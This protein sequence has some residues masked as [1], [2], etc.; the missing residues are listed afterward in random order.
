MFQSSPSPIARS[1]ALRSIGAGAVA[2]AVMASEL[3]VFRTAAEAQGF[4]PVTIGLVNSSSDAPFFLA[5]QLGYYRDAGIAAK[6]IAFNGGAPAM[7]SSVGA[8]QID[9]GSGGPSAGLYN[10]IAGKIDLRMVA[11][12][13]TPAPGNGYAP[14]MVRSELVSSGK[15]KSPRDLKGM[16]F[17][18]AG[19]GS[20]TSA[21]IARLLTSV[22]LHYSDLQRVIL[23]FPDQIVAFSNGAIDAAMPLEPNATIAE[24]QGVAVRVMSNDKW[25][26]YEEQ[27]VVFYG[28][29]LL[30]RRRDIGTRFMV[31]Y[32]RA[33]RFY[34]DALVGG[35]LRGRTAKDVIDVLVRTTSVK[36]PTIY[37]DMVSQ[38]VNVD[39]KLNVNSL[40]EDL[41][42][43]TEQGWI[44]AP[45][46]AAQSVDN[47][48]SVAALRQ[49]G[50]YKPNA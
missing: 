48:F 38:A 18:E 8:G 6:L 16:K 20:T 30:R 7:I 12:K 29:T 39:G 11:D 3:A 14:L 21:S 23:G 13:A 28:P 33:V 43:F 22:G 49:L 17:A 37:R 27:A 5:D 34:N 24:R 9:V 31:A 32:L 41:A 45:I 15:Y 44:T 10:A 50:P 47:E 4:A 40:A 35:H 1:A 36:D 19:S 46:T 25:S 42:F 26:P 2:A